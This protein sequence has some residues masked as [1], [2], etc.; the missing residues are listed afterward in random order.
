MNVLKL[1]SEYNYI[2]GQA[3][4]KKL[5]ISRAAINKQINMLRRSGYSIDGVKNLGYKLVSISS[6]DFNAQQVITAASQVSLVTK[7]IFFIKTNSTQTQAKKNADI[8]SS[9]TLIIASEQNSAYGRMERKWSASSGGLW[10]SLLLKPKMLLQNVAQMSLVAS[11]SVAQA[12]INLGFSAKIKWP[13]DIFITGKKVCGILVETAAEAD[14]VRWIALGIGL[15]INNLLPYELLNTSTTLSLEK[16]ATVS[17]VEIL[18]EVLLEFEKA[19]TQFLKDGFI[20]MK[21]NYNTLSY[22]I[23]KNVK[24]VS[25][26]GEYFGKAIGIDSYGRLLIEQNGIVS[27]FLSGDVSV[28][29][30]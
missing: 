24:V 1:L 20:S 4:A 22:L 25:L 15:N 27:K 29:I 9:G 13:N 10:F 21:D 19:Y 17:R 12:L 16:G 3:I 18:R 11:L 2:S 14:M 30:K 7:T 23:N 6:D 28:R 8:H 26:D 5:K